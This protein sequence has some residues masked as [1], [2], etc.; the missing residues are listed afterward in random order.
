MTFI[1]AME[2]P[3]NHE[4]RCLLAPREER[5]VC[6]SR[7]MSAVSSL[8]RVAP[9]SP[10]ASY[11]RQGNCCL[12]SCATAIALVSLNSLVIFTFVHTFLHTRHATP[13]SSPSQQYFLLHLRALRAWA[14]HALLHA[15]PFTLTLTCSTLLQSLPHATRPFSLEARVQPT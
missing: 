11:N 15:L 6:L 9:A 2:L 4:Q 5:F 7:K 3:I 14:H 13:T 1:Q 10:P 8:P 12:V